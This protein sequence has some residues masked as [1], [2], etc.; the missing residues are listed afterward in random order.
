L[1]H[2]ERNKEKGFW[3][4]MSF[5]AIETTPRAPVSRSA[6]KPAVGPKLK[7]ALV[8]VFASFALLAATGSY[9]GSVTFLN[10]LRW[11]ETYTSQFTLWM[12]LVHSGIGIL[13]IVPFL[14]FGGYHWL[15]ARQRPNRKAVRLGL[16]VFFGG[17]LIC[18]TGVALFQF[19]GLPQLPTGTFIRTLVYALHLLIPL[20]VIIGY[21]AHRRAGPRIRWSWGYSWA[22]GT[23]GFIAIMLVMH[24]QEPQKW[25]AIGPAEGERY[26]FPSSARTADGKFIPASVLM[27]DSY[28]MKCHQDIFQ[29]WFH[30]SHHFS[31]FNN[32]PYLFS[33]RETR[34]VSLQRLG[35]VKASRWCAGCHDPVPFFS[36]AFDDPNFDDVNHPAAHAGITCTACH[37]ITHVNDPTGNG[38]F[39]IG[40][41]P[42]YPLTFSDN[43]ILQHINQQLIKAK[44]DFH[45]KTFLKPL[46]KS[47][48]FC[49]TCHKVS[50]PPV[51]TYYREFQRGQNHYDSFHLSGASGH[52]ARSFYYPPEGKPK[53]A[54][55]HMPLRA[56]ANDL[57]AK[58]FDASGERKVHSHLFPAANTGLPALLKLE[59][60]YSDKASGFDRAISEHEAFLKDKKLRIDL[61]A[62]KEG[63]TIEGKLLGPLRPELPKLKPGSTYLVEVVVRTLNLGHHFSQGT[64]DSNEIWVDFTAKSGNRIIGRNGALEHSENSGPLD[65]WAHR[66]NVL[67]LDRE[68]KRIDRRN[69][70]D[71]FTPLYDHQIPP[72]AA[73]VV[74]Y[75][76]NVPSDVRDPIELI[77]KVRYRKF[78]YAYMEYVHKE[79]KI[80]VPALP[81]VDLCEDRV[82]LPIESSALPSPLG[83]EGSGARGGKAP[84][85][86]SPIKPAWQRWNDYGIG[87][88]LEGGAGSKRGEPRQAAQAFQ[89]MVTLGDKEA[90]A[91]GHLNLARVLIEEGRLTEASDQIE[92]ARKAD[93]PAPWWLIAWFSGIVQAE[94]ASKPEDLDRA[95]SY[96]EQILDP[97]NQPTNRKFDFTSDYI[98]IDRLAQTL[99]RRAQMAEGV[100]GSE[101][102]ERSQNSFVQRAIAAYEKVLALEPEMLDSHFGLS[103]CFAMLASNGQSLT[104]VASDSA[105]EQ[106]GPLVDALADGRRSAEE[107]IA[108]AYRLARVI[109]DWHQ[110]PINLEQPRLPRL[111]RMSKQLYALFQE[112]SPASLKTAL[113]AALAQV[114]L[115][116]HA[117]L[118]PDELARAQAIR[119]YRNGHPADNAAADPIVIY[120]TEPTE[121]NKPQA[122]GNR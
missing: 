4:S 90:V 60:R 29:D 39:T 14:W 48:E 10:F 106:P 73:S 69:P 44:P 87:C 15:T 104:H 46:H 8:I 65:P 109:S 22:A 120:P 88:L 99:F 80:P 113:A 105:N 85:Q 38:S 31:S 72:G 119:I 26:F 58:D 82:T 117:Q 43:P 62:L 110:Q 42:H 35:N 66:I 40:N 94:N 16:L 107:K 36:G 70:Q 96:F 76:V 1:C 98:V 100:G 74:H 45:K 63:E 121:K 84:H 93:P 51:L 71:I 18:L 21:L 7:V 77:A 53:C 64:V 122:I 56:S 78:D 55:C 47:P 5:A 13:S 50:L 28:C 11:P 67:V 89:K 32:P 115:Q 86:E 27:M 17:I 116:I 101:G 12:F 41:P 79:K 6:Y 83:G 114:H 24:W 95:I 103:Q 37:A 25:F 33:V 75:R 118:K 3:R 30:S 49:S 102:N 97:K 91:H 54:D 92:K 19:E 9:L 108:S 61:F 34:K 52:G 20:A 68:G 112:A 57:G 2:N 81:I 111:Q 23:A 59:P